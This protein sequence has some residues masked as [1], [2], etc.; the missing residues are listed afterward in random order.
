MTL[1][2]GRKKQVT[3]EK[4]IE[5]DGPIWTHMGSYV[6]I[7]SDGP[8]DP[9]WAQWAQMGRMGSMNPMSLMGPI[10]P[11]EPP[12][13]WGFGGRMGGRFLEDSLSLV[14]PLPCNVRYKV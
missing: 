9:S 2:V 7:G 6:P 4:Q 8:T 10:G 11:M 5:P 12:W 3:E 13:A 1:R 14:R